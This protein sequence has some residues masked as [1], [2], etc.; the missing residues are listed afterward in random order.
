MIPLTQVPRAVKFRE[1]KEKGGFQG[2]GKGRNGELVLMDVELQF[3]EMKQAL[4][5]AGGD[6]CTVM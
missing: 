2:L 5:V 4:W 3:C 1:G 6:G